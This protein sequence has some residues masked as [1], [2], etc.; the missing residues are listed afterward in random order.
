MHPLLTLL[1]FF[2]IVF[3]GCVF[4]P[5]GIATQS[6]E[7]NNNND[8]TTND[9]GNGVLDPGE[10]CDGDDLRGETC[11]SLGFREGSLSCT[12]ECEFKTSECG[13]PPVC[14]DGVQDPGEE[15]DGDDLGGETCES[16]GLGTGTLG[17]TENCMFDTSECS[18]PP[19][20][21]DGELNPGEQCDDGNLAEDDGC[22]SLCEIEQGWRCDGEPSD[23]VVWSCTNSSTF[24]AEWIDQSWGFRTLIIIDHEKVGED[25]VDFPVLVYIDSSEELAASAQSS[26]EDI[27]FTHEDGVSVLDHEIQRFDDTTGKLAVWVKVPLLLSDYHTLIY[28]YYGEPDVS[29]QEYPFGVWSNGYAAVLHLQ[30]DGSGNDDEFF[31]SSGNNING[32]GGG[33]SGSGNADRTPV[34]VEGWCGYAQDFDGGDDHIRLRNTLDHNWSAVTV[35]VWMN[36]NDGGDDRVFGKS[37]GTGGSDNVWLLGKDGNI[38][39]RHRTNE[40][41]DE[42]SNGGD[43]WTSGEWYH[44]AYTWDADNNGTVKCY[45]NGVVRITDTINGQ[46]LYEDNREP[47]IGNVSGSLNRGF[48]GL[49]Q[50]ARLSFVARSE[51]WM[52]TEYNNVSD[53][54]SFYTIHPEEIMPVP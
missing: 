14:G 40:D 3:A 50:E 51:G 22:S 10:E 20:C 27:L 32:T 16:I 17:C 53:P 6:N 37:W 54:E 25:L 42:F 1:L 23:C 34:R 15:C 8:N 13:D 7:T 38:K 9:C 5:E 24:C 30:E 19:V 35:Q 2:F 4:D 43:N 46:S 41:S 21:G 49:I 31:D 47:I 45:Q 12:E 44:F 36:P 26:G 39:V 18:D 33:V 52:L 29:S 28:L 48:S 11:E